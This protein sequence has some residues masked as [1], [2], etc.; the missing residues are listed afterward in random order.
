MSLARGA[1]VLGQPC[2]SATA[3]V[4]APAFWLDSPADAR[5]FLRA[6]REGQA[7]VHGLDI[8]V[9]RTCPVVIIDESVN[10]VALVRYDSW[11]IDEVGAYRWSQDQELADCVVNSSRIEGASGAGL[12]LT[13]LMSAHRVSVSVR[14]LTGFI[15]VQYACIAIRDV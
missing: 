11:R 1:G 3:K 4:L 13:F 14:I 9:R 10:S 7:A 12:V 6:L 8:I 15:E 2:A 5:V